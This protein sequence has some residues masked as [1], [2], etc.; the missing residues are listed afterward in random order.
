MITVSLPIHMVP[1]LPHGPFSSWKDSLKTELDYNSISLKLQCPFIAVKKKHTYTNF[2]G[3]SGSMWHASLSLLDFVFLSASSSKLLSIPWVRPV[4]SCLRLF[5]ILFLPP[6]MPF[7]PI[8][9]LSSNITSLDKTR[10]IQG[11]MA[12]E[13]TSSKNSF[14]TIRSKVISCPCHITLFIFFIV[15]TTF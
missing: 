1:C 10:C 15:L 7:P 13:V 2:L 5:G 14:L 4:S 12:I 3:L 6:A 9:A 8:F 11:G